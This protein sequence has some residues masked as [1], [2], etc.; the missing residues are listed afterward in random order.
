MPKVTR[1]YEVKNKPTTIRLT[2]HQE[3][4]VQEYMSMAGISKN[5]AIGELIEKGHE[6]VRVLIV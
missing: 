1:S 6:L 2:D 3:K 5:Q 4:I